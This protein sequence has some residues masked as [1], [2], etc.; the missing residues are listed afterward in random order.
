MSMTKQETEATARPR[1]DWVEASV[2]T[3]RM[4]AALEN[5]VTGG[6]WYSLIDTVSA[7]GTLQAAWGRVAANGGA[8]GVDRMSI[9]RFQAKEQQYLE[10]LSQALREGRYHPMAVRRVQIPKGQGQMRPLGVCPT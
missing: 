7:P 4:L 10:E 1:G 6:K 9:E 8:A 3:E 5:G 2:W